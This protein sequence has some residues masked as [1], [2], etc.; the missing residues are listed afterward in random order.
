MSHIS[1][2]GDNNLFITT[3]KTLRSLSLLISMALLVASCQQDPQSA[4][5]PNLPLAQG[6][7]GG[8]GSTTPANPAITYISSTTS[9]GHTTWGIAVMD[10]SGANQTVIYT[11]S[12]GYIVYNPTWS[13]TGGSI[14]FA[15]SDFSLGVSAI[16]VI[17]VSVNSSGVAVGS[18]LR[19][20]ASWSASDSEGV[21]NNDDD[22]GPA[23]CQQ[24]TTGKIAFLLYHTNWSGSPNHYRTDLCTIP[25]AGGT[26][27]MLATR[28][29]SNNGVAD[30]L[31]APTWSPDDSHIAARVFAG[32]PDPV[33][34]FDMTGAVTDSTPL[35]TTSTNRPVRWSHSGLNELV[36][37]SGGTNPMYYLTPGSSPTSE[38]ITG[39][40]GTWS[41]NN[42]GIMYLNG[43]AMLKVIPNT[44]TATT[45][46]SSA[47]G[48]GGNLD[49]RQN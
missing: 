41:P 48:I 8:G 17:D 42:S 6:G 49:W 18:N 45:V 12:T 38:S 34:V 5:G 28:T 29:P 32:G 4:N 47:S 37:G 46:L 30:M 11:P 13:P 39:S 27:T 10:T 24:S 9:H 35:A 23:W 19:T 21:F 1:A 33:L 22:C 26:V 40:T 36:I 31:F 15:E 25:Q 7:H 44:T 2:L 14:A 3:M 43:G 16:K 20:I